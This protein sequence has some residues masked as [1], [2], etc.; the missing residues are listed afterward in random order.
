MKKNPNVTLLSPGAE[1]YVSVDS[2]N[3]HEIAHAKG[4]MA[5]KRKCSNEKCFLVNTGSYQPSYDMMLKF[6]A[7]FKQGTE[8]T[9]TS[10]R[11]AFW[12]VVGR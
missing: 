4:S 1:I 3:S 6:Y 11:P 12:D 8:G 5:T 2:L 7:Y 9:C 10:R